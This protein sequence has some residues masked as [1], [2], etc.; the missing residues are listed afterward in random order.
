M[1]ASPLGVSQPS[2]PDVPAIEYT[3][4]RYEQDGQRQRQADAQRGGW[5]VALDARTAAR[6]WAVQVYA[7]PFDAAS[8]VGSPA[9]WFSRMQLMPGQDK[10]EIEDTLGARYVVDLKS[11]SV[12]Q[13]VDP[14]G[15]QGKPKA[16]ARPKFD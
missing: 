13:T 9:R 11:R 8:P 16:D 6:L 3:G 1:S 12:T 15:P 10:I 4:V 2:P 5:L 7:N 14:I